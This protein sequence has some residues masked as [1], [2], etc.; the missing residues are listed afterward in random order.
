MPLEISRTQPTTNTTLDTL[1]AAIDEA[2]DV[3]ESAVG[4]PKDSDDVR[5]ARDVVA[6][7]NAK[8]AE[9]LASLAGDERTEAQRA[10]GLKVAKM[11]GLLSRLES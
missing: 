4:E 2:I 8:Y 1:R 9:L 3:V 5:E 10:I 7:V 11:T 6:Q